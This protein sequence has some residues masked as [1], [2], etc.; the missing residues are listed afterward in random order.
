MV[1]NCHVGPVDDSCSTKHIH[2]RM[3]SNAVQNDHEA[4]WQDSEIT[5]GRGSNKFE[6]KK[7]VHQS[8]SHAVIPVDQSSQ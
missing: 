1:P 5:E 4:Y 8:F 6:A 2:D 7:A 3:L